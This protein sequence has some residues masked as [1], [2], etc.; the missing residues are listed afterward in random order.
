MKYQSKDGTSEL[1]WNSRDGVTPFLIRLRSGAEAKHVDWQRDQYLPNYVP[2]VGERIFVDYTPDEARASAN[3][4]YDNWSKTHPEFM[5]D[6]PDR[7][8][9]VNQQA[10]SILE[11]FWPHSPHL[12]EVTAELRTE[13]MRPLPP[14]ASPEGR[15]RHQ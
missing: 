12:V 9:F 15:V 7:K 11:G 13:F 6:H 3:R 1:I 4:Q 2:E 8:A 10:L 14:G 5:K